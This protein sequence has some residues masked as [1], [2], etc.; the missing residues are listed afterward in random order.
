M[1]DTRFWLGGLLLLQL[2]LATGLAWNHRQ[3]G[4]GQPP[5]PLLEVAAG[6]VDRI[7][8][9][10]AD[11][12]EAV[13]TREG[14][15]W[16]LP[17]LA[18][19]P[20]SGGKVSETL[21]K[22]AAA[23]T[24][25]PVATTDSS[26]ARFEVADE[27]FQRRLQLYHGDEQ[28]AEFYLGTSPGLRKVHL[29]RAGETPVYD[30]DL[31]TYDLPATDD[32]WLDKS[33]L[34]LDDASRIA[35][36]DYTLQ[37]SDQGTWNL[38]GGAAAGLDDERARQLVSAFSTLR[39]QSVAGDVTPEQLA[40]GKRVALRVTAGEQEYSY[41]FSTVD[42]RHYVQR[43]DLESVFELSQYDFDRIAEVD[44]AELALKPD[45]KEAAG[46]ATVQSDS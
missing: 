20:A 28:L 41:Q 15:G 2:V 30:V 17:A 26:H 11:G 40:G 18:G 32:G 10:G 36:P 42:Q 23:K 33:L 38:T 19:L 14:D 39:V 13:I 35:G 24:E 12:G 45:E 21:E 27:K 34:A 44:L 16:R 9:G 31:S 7:V 37:E 3:A 25:W 8:V 46:E 1:N 5:R 43:D 4:G 6:E 22:L 29:R